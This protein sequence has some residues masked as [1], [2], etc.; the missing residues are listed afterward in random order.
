MYSF[1]AQIVSFFVNLCYKTDF[2][3]AAKNSQIETDRFWLM[4][5]DAAGSLGH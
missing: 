1:L 2:E 5:C 3:W 4:A